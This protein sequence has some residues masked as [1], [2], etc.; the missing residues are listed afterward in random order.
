MQCKYVSYLPIFQK[1]F[2]KSYLRGLQVDN[3][4]G[5]GSLELMRL[6]KGPM[7]L[8][9]LRKNGLK[10]RFRLLIS[11]QIHVRFVEIYQKSRCCSSHTSVETG[12]QLYLKWN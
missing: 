5:G 2:G 9:K 6:T 8:E 10:Q 3:S 11:G 4:F 7:V 12:C 1:R